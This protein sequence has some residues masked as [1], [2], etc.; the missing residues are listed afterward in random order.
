M[1][2]EDNLVNQKLAVIL[3]QKRGH[4][5]TVAAN[6]RQALEAWQRA[7]FDLVLM[8]MEMP[9][10]D[11][12]AATQAIRAG[13]KIS[14]GHIP[15]IAMTAHAMAEHRERCLAEGMDDYLTKPL[16]PQKLFEV[17][18]SHGRAPR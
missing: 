6:G 15:I 12:L 2:A 8:D 18:E 13:E 5:V 7:S 9:E 16:E 14:G 11:G 4:Q 1:L 3:L 10:M 17:V